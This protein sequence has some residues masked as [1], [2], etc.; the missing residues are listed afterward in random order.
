[1]KND[2]AFDAFDVTSIFVLPH[3]IIS[4]GKTVVKRL[5]RKYFLGCFKNDCYK[6]L[7]SVFEMLLVS[8]L[9]SGI[10]IEILVNMQV[11]NDYFLSSR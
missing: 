8:I 6:A 1:M 2:V 7:L 4:L 5:L 10:F 11:E 9:I 3:V